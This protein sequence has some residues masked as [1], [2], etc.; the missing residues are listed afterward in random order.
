[1][2]TLSGLG[3]DSFEH[4][5]DRA[6]EVF[7]K[8]H[9]FFPENKL[10]EWSLTPCNWTG[11]RTLTFTNHYFTQRHE[12]PLTQAI[13]FST[14][15]DPANILTDMIT[16]MLFHADDNKVAYYER[17]KEDLASVHCYIP[18]QTFCLG[19]IIDVQFCFIAYR[20]HTKQYV[21]KLM[22]YSI[23]LIE[24]K[25]A[26]VSKHTDV[27]TDADVIACTY[28]NTFRRN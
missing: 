17:Y 15:V 8:F 18:P 4:T 7:T 19:D 27:I 21:L 13:Q 14:E 5:V 26:D 9:R 1:M 6:N 12:A 25:F 20:M 16:A 24:A 2:I 3:T 10:Q 11:T 22:L 28:R 23:T